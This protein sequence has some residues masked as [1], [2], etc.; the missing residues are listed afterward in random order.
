MGAYKRVKLSNGTAS[1]TNLGFFLIR[2]PNYN[3]L[4][5]SSPYTR[6]LSIKFNQDSYQMVKI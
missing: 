5:V 2:S 1:D 6:C 4:N 3:L